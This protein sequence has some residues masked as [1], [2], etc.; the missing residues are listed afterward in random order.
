MLNRRGR[1]E[2]ETTVVR[3]AQ[4]RFY[5]VCAAFFEQR[6]IDH[7]TFNR[8]GADAQII[9]RSSDWAAIALQGPKARDILGVCT[10]ANLENA[11]F[12]WLSAQEIEDCRSS[13][14]GAARVLWR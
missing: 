4:D 11:A 1:I 8:D 5:L 10:D 2:L 12:R 7:L 14:V 13:G 3:M 6:L 9:N